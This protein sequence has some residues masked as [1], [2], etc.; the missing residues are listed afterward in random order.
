MTNFKSD[1]CIRTGVGNLF[2]AGDRMKIK[3]V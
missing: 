2:W 1:A 3:I